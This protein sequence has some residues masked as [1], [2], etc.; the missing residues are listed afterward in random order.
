MARAPARFRIIRNR[1]PLRYWLRL[2]TAAILA[3]VPAVL[4][5]GVTAQPAPQRTDMVARVVFSLLGYARWPS[6]REPVRLCVDNTS[7]YP[8]RLLEGGTLSN[9]RTVRTREVDVMTEAL[10]S[11]CDALYLGA[12]TDAR[13]QR[14]GVELTGRPVLVISEEDFECEVGSMFC[15]NIRENQ[16]SFRVNLDSLARS[17]VHVHPA[18]LQLGRRRGASS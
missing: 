10:A 5:P 18:V 3:I 4:P 17:G 6:E 8:A 16:V 1:S 15:L 9:G 14:L 11:N 2:L 7:R 13:R 12:M